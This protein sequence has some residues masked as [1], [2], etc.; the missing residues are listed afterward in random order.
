VCADAIKVLIEY[1]ADLDRAASN[2]GYTPM[3]LAL[4]QG[5][6]DAVLVLLYA[7]AD[8]HVCDAT[9]HAPLLGHAQAAARAG[10]PGAAA[11]VDAVEHYLA[12]RAPLA[13]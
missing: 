5:H 1:G 9:A 12:G 11:L 4:L 13:L 7:G 10:A 6:H 8:P 3:M 2:D